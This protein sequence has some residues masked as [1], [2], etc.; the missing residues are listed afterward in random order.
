MRAAT[1]RGTCPCSARPAASPSTSSSR[2][3]CEGAA[4][5]EHGGRARRS[6]RLHERRSHRS[7][8]RPR[9]SRRMPPVEQALLPD[10]SARQRGRLHRAPG[11]SCT[12]HVSW[13]RACAHAHRE[14]VGAKES[15]PAA[16]SFAL[17]STVIARWQWRA[18]AVSWRKRGRDGVST[19]TCP[20]QPGA[21]PGTACPCVCDSRATGDVD[22]VVGEPLPFSVHG[23]FARARL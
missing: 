16:R 21:L 1:S 13:G 17:G 2:Q 18:R 8:R 4:T 9:W 14:G 22:H 20:E 15:A 3:P 11:H 19:P 6:D 7:R 12:R 5:A 10:V 23:T